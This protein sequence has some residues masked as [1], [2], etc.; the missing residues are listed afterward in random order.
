M[1]IFKQL[2]A[3]FFVVVS[4]WLQSKI[5]TNMYNFKV[6][7][8]EY[9]DELYLAYLGWPWCVPAMDWTYITHCLDIEA[10]QTMRN[11]SELRHCLRCNGSRLA[12]QRRPICSSVLVTLY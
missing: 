12:T 2:R 8:Q 11:V 7:L 4:P 5:K 3:K 10:V 1:D 9:Y 6:F